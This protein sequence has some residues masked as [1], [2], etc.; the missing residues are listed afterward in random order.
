MTSVA[1][2]RPVRMRAVAGA[3]GNAMAVA[4]PVILVSTFVTYSLG[5][6][7]D[8]NPAAAALGETATPADIARLNHEFGLDRPFLIRYVTWL[9][10]ALT[11]DFG[12]SWFTQIP[13]AES[14][15]QRLP[16]SL[17]VA[18][19]ALL[20]AVVLGTAG[21]V[22][23]ALNNGGW[24]D[25]SITAVCAVLSTVPA[26]VA[27]IGLIVVF[28]VLVPILPA[29]GYVSFAENPGQWLTF[30]ILPCIALS[31]DSAADL[32]R[33]LRTGL[34]GALAENYVTGAVM[35]GFSVR[36]VVFVH[37]LR[38]GAGPAI[39]VLGLHVPRLI[40]GAVITETVFAMPGL[41]QLAR[42][43]ALKGDVPVVQGTLLVSVGLVL[44][45]SAVVNLALRRL[46]PGSGRTV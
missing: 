8:H 38:N 24:L 43:S 28:A 13:V 17:S 35:R 26:F 22:V 27:A 5:A 37:A 46:R 14:I 4:V 15:A 16:V 9:G 12:K 2:V 30:L 10:D 33:Q 23:A 3:I 1:L 40:G 34:V 45:S 19:F 11:G 7:S 42:D 32:A 21:G 31:L 41:G 18:V 20:L 36:R 44:V 39:A 25:R 29:G 6:L